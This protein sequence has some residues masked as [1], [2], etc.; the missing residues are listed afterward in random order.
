MPV[1]LREERGTH[2]IVGEAHVH[3]QESDKINLR[4]FEIF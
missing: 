3:G 2:R 1:V 4:D